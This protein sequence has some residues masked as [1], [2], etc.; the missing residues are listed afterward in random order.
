MYLVLHHR[1]NLNRVEIATKTWMDR[2]RSNHLP[3]LKNLSLNKILCKEKQ[4]EKSAF[5]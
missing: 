2:G 3:A 4:K 5:E 1:V